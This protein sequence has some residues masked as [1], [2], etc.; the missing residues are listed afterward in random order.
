MNREYSTQLLKR[1]VWKLRWRGTVVTM[2]LPVRLC[3]P[4]IEVSGSDTIN[5]LNRPTGC[6]RTFN[7]VIFSTAINQFAD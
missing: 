1:A 2:I 6:V 7:I 4:H 3:N 5:I